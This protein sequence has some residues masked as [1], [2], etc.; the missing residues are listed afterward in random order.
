MVF[1]NTIL[2]AYKNLPKELKECNVCHWALPRSDFYKRKSATGFDSY[3][4]KCKNKRSREGERKNP[5]RERLRSR[6]WR[7]DNPQKYLISQ[8]KTSLKYKYNISVE[9][10]DNMYIC[11]GGR[12]AICGKHQSE[13]DRRLCVDHCHKTGKN[14]GLLCINCNKGIG[15][16]YDN[17]SVLRNAI[18]YLEGSQ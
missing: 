5:E 17:S 7:K 4:K 11:Q 14:R 10:Y 1:T 16:F 9:E 2:R 8:R 6:Q 3:C 12:C 18:K 15:H 13:F